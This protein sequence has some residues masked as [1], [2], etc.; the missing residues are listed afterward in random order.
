MGKLIAPKRNAHQV[1]L[2]IRIKLILKSVRQQF[3]FLVEPGM[4][5]KGTS[6]R[7]DCNIC[8]CDPETGETVCT[9]RKSCLKVGEQF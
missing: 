7:D 3:Y 9:K 6:Y 8:A 1:I 4:C 5:K 2:A